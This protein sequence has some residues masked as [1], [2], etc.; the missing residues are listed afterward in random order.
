[1]GGITFDH[2]GVITSG[3]PAGPQGGLGPMDI[4]PTARAP[5]G[6]A[7]IPAISPGDQDRIKGQLAQYTEGGTRAYQAAQG[8]IGG[9]NI[10]DSS[11]DHLAS[12]GGFTV[13]GTAGA[14]RANLGKFVNTVQGVLGAKPSFDPASIASAE[15]LQKQ[16]NT[17]AFQLA[18][19]YEGNQRVAA[20]T[21]TKALN[22]VPGIDNSYLGAKLLADGIRASAQ[23]QMDF[24][25][26]QTQWLSDPRRAGKGADLGNSDVAFNKAN[27]PEK[28]TNAIMAK[29]GLTNQGFTS[30]EAVGKLVQQHLLE[31]E[32]AATILRS[33]FSDKF[34]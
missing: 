28:Y 3:P 7:G 26:F 12:N 31:P 34:K 4:S 25:E 20:E 24:H 10:L 6:L 8:V 16:T 30:P 5:L 14:V 17:L 13:P 23:R 15:D 33:Q 21:I 19:Q 32:Q 29:Y 18:N 9:L 11:L 2:N 22:A 1:M 27:P